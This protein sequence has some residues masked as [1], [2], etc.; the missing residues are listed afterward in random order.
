MSRLEITYCPGCDESKCEEECGGDARD[1]EGE[2]L[3]PR[4]LRF[5]AD[6]DDGLFLIEI[7]FPRGLNVPSQLVTSLR[8]FFEGIRQ[9][10][11][12]VVWHCLGVRIK[13]VHEDCGVALVMVRNERGKEMCEEVVDE[14]AR[15]RVQPKFKV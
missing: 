14:G 10:R 11:V 15:K 5:V 1:D 3:L 6:E 12:D 9:V 2:V 8:L 13:A 4:L 7:D